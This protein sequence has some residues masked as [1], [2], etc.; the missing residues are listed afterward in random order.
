M[1]SDSSHSDITSPP[2]A[3]TYSMHSPN[4][5]T[6]ISPLPPSYQPPDSPAPLSFDRNNIPFITPEHPLSERCIDPKL[7]PIR[8]SFEN[9][10]V[11]RT[12]ITTE[13]VFHA[14]SKASPKPVPPMH[15]HASNKENAVHDH[16]LLNPVDISPIKTRCKA[17][18]GS[19]R[20]DRSSHR[21]SSSPTRS[22]NSVRPSASRSSSPTELSPVKTRSVSPRDPS[23][24]K[25]PSRRRV[26]PSPSPS[27]SKNK[28]T[29]SNSAR[30]P[31]RKARVGAETAAEA[32]ARQVRTGSNAKE[33]SARLSLR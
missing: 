14:K 24:A 3:V 26:T 13:D 10:F 17:C 2:L 1:S 9:P 6:P 4:C 7:R 15:I 20:R 23:P 33:S 5:G 27:P 18:H 29:R 22:P 31:L 25:S 16:T 12:S 19:P 28:V 30:S 11:A 21:L 8:G 32:Y